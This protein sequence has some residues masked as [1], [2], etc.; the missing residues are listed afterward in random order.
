MPITVVG[1]PLIPILKAVAPY[2]AQIASIAIPAFTHRSAETGPA[3]P[4]VAKQ[5]QE[6]QEAA[7][8]NAEAMQVLVVSGASLALSAF[9]IPN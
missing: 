3:D 5:I 7:T 6:L 1:A 8:H 4:V 9:L 2:V